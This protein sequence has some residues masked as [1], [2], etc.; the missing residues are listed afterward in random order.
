MADAERLQ[1]RMPTTPDTTEPTPTY[2][3][4]MLVDA[5]TNLDSF[6]S[7]MPPIVVK[8]AAITQGERINRYKE[9]GDKVAYSTTHRM[10]EAASAL[11]QDGQY[12]LTFSLLTDFFEEND[13]IRRINSGFFRR[14]SSVDQK[15]AAM[16]VEY[17]EKWKGF[18]AS[19]EVPRE[20]VAGV[21]DAITN[22]Y[23][24]PYNL[25][26]EV[27]TNDP[28]VVETH[29]AMERVPFQ[30][31]LHVLPDI[32]DDEAHKLFWEGITAQHVR[33][34]ASGGEIPTTE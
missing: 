15:V 28:F 1:G 7:I 30:I 19:G 14:F 34:I 27:Q 25:P 33:D 11:M 26:F 2:N 8:T 18:L 9:N 5:A 23:G 17:Q 20:R 31:A 24:E 29:R 6:L 13:A 12:M 3:P 32:R 16:P 4:R 21:I 22:L 10:E